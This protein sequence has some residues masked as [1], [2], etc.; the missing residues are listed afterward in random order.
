MVTN[1]IKDLFSVCLLVLGIELSVWLLYPMNDIVRNW[2][3]FYH[4]EKQSV[5][6]L[7]IGSSHAYSSFD[8]EIFLEGTGEKS[9]ILGS[10]SQNVVQ[11]YYNVKEALN[12]QTPKRII[13]EAFSFDSNNNWR[14]ENSENDDKD[15]KKESNIDGMKFGLVKLEAVREQYRPKNWIYALFPLIRCHGNWKDVSQICS[16][17][18]FFKNDID[19]FSSFR[20]SQ[21]VMG[22]ETMQKYAQAEKDI[23]RIS[24]SGANS[25][26]FHKL[27]ELCREKGIKLY[28]VMAPMYD[29]YID[30]INYDSWLSELLALTES[31]H[32]DYLDCNLNYDRIGLTAQDFEDAYNGYHHLNTSGAE[33]VTK[34]VEEELYGTEKNR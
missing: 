2:R 18:S 4:L 34:F 5:D 17:Y 32:V 24:I 15:W 3:S 1:L 13:L 7:I 28:V 14:D 30:S 20:P 22:S 29:V 25:I 10:N 33:K 8:T 12:Y 11:S 19:E 16:N 6:T 23:S 21:S 9:Y 26:H 27:A 31:E